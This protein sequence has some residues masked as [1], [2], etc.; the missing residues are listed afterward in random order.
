MDRGYWWGY[1]RVEHNLVTKQQKQLIKNQL[2]LCTPHLVDWKK[3][4]YL[5]VMFYK[6]WLIIRIILFYWR[7]TG[8]DPDAGKDWR[9]E[10][11]GTT[12]DEMVGWHH[13]LEGHEFEQALGVGDGQQSLVCCS[14]WG[15]KE[16]DMTERLKWTE[17]SQSLKLPLLFTNEMTNTTCVALKPIAFNP[18]RE[19]QTLTWS[20]LG[21]G[22]LV[23]TS[24]ALSVISKPP[25]NQGQ[26]SSQ[27][28]WSHLPKPR[29]WTV[30]LSG[31]FQVLSF[32]S[33]ESILYCHVS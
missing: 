23:N 14:P 29:K 10:E 5:A 9:Q 24:R 8:K 16:L 12:D 11:K 4:G 30:D 20:G 6:S 27:P 1:R 21:P 17:K 18:P 25:S 26:R 32:S 7:L 2:L 22:V 3:L 15:C 28:S 13:W 19:F 31:N 33:I